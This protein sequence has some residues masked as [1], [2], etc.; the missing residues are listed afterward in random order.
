MALTK[1]GTDSI[2]D[3]AVTLAKQAAGTDGQIITYDASGNPTTVGPGTDGQ[4]LTST[5]AGSPPAFETLSINSQSLTAPNGSTRILVDNTDIN[6]GYAPLK[7]DTD[8]SNTYSIKVQGPS[9]L[10]KDSSFTLPEDGTN[11]QYLK[12]NGSGALSFATVSTTEAAATPRTSSASNVYHSVVNNITWGSTVSGD[13]SL[14]TVNSSL[15]ASGIYAIEVYIQAIHGASSASHNYLNGWFYQTGKTY[16]VDGVYLSINIYNQYL[17]SLPFTF[18]LPWDPSG[19]QSL[20]C[21]VTS[22]LNTDTNNYFNIG[23]INKLEN[24]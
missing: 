12:T 24:V 6:V 22:A 14:S 20:N 5:G 4:I 16:N 15:S 10:T 17:V 1:I 21:Y 19:T 9:T 2:K 11:G 7:F 3:D 23:V 18:I 8:T 13:Q